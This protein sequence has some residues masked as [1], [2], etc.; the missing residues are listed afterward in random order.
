[1]Q[2]ST[3]CLSVQYLSAIRML[4]ESSFSLR[5][6]IIS[7]LRKSRC[8]KPS[9]KTLAFEVVREVLECIRSDSALQFEDA[10]VS[11]EVLQEDLSPCC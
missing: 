2:N 7:K 3:D 11:P 1:M 4:P 10:S 9:K 6:T 5:L 8:E